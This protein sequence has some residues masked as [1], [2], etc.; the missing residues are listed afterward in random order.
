MPASGDQTPQ[1]QGLDKCVSSVQDNK[2]RGYYVLEHR[3]GS[4][5]YNVSCDHQQEGGMHVHLP[6]R[7]SSCQIL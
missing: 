6:Y 7:V 2:E 4:P 5:S 3:Q 1:H